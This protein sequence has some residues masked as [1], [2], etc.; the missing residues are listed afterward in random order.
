MIDSKVVQ[1]T[2]DDHDQIRKIFFRVSQ[3]IFHDPRALDARN[4]V[5]HSNPDFRYLA[6]ALFLFGS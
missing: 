5:F 6:I 4:G 1:A 2:G 3:S